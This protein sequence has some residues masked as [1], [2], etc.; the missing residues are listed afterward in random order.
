MN[1]LSTSPI[2]SINNL[3]ATSTTLFNKT[4]FTNFLVS[5][6]STCS[7]SLNIVSNI[8]GSGTALT[9]LNYNAITNPPATTSQWTTSGAYIYIYI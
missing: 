6:T 3:N 4:N 1:S 9:Y 5:G 2:L 8:I 7:A